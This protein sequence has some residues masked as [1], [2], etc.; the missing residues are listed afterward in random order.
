LSGTT[1]TGGKYDIAGVFQLAHAD[2]ETVQ[3]EVILHGFA[4]IVDS[5]NSVN[6]LAGLGTIGTQGKLRLRDGA[7]FF[8]INNTVGN[9]GVLELGGGA[10]NVDTLNNTA[11]GTILGSGDINATVTNAG[12]VSP[13]TSP[14]VLRISGAYTQSATGVLEIGISGDDNSNPLNPQFDVLEVELMAN[15]NGLLKVTLEG[16]FTP[17]AADV[18]TILDSGP[19]GI[20]GVFA[21]VAN[22]QRLFTVGGEGSF[23]V[24]YNVLAGN[25]IL[26]G[27]ARPGDFDSDGDVDGVDFVTWQNHFPTA[28]GALL[29]DGDADGDGDVDGADFIVWQTNFPFSPAPGVAPVPEPASIGLAMCS[30]AVLAFLRR[31][32]QAVNCSRT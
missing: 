31:R 22:G 6:A 24:S 32:F 14:G 17:S 4:A 9:A 30:C 27:F 3:A 18:F 20:S 1:L 15:L 28:S 25:V 5:F 10:F 11:T 26:S 2:I 12:T 29:V 8:A 23:L 16:G 13:G 19:S 7:S 21:N